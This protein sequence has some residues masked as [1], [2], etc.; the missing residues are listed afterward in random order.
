[1]YFSSAV[2]L[3]FFIP[4]FLFLRHGSLISF[5]FENWFIDVSK[6]MKLAEWMLV[7]P[8]FWAAWVLP[9]LIWILYIVISWL[10][11]KIGVTFP[12]PNDASPSHSNLIQQHSQWLPYMF[13]ITDLL[14]CI[15]QRVLLFVDFFLFFFNLS[16][17]IHTLL[18]IFSGNQVNV[19]SKHI[20]IHS[21]Q[22]PI[23]N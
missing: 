2:H 4:K 9:K 8:L 20:C 23:L 17:V 6:G 18:V 11:C 21:P 3:N 19:W 7:A 1:M 5:L 16:S 12:S 22:Y 13:L 10:Q 14:V 15:K